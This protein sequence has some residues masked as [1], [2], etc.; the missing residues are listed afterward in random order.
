MAMHAA[1]SHL[2]FDADRVL[3]EC[4]APLTLTATATLDDPD[5]VARL[6]NDCHSD[7]L[8]LALSLSANAERSRIVATLPA[9][10]ADHNQYNPRGGHSH[11]TLVHSTVASGEF[12]TVVELVEGSADLRLEDFHHESIALDWAVYM[13]RDAIATFLRSRS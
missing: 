5:A 12:D 7:D 4:G 1:L 11:C 3:L 6:I 9:A 13:K 10:V 2:E 8:P